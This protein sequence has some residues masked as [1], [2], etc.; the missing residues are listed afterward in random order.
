MGKGCLAK[1]IPSKLISSYIQIP[2]EGFILRYV[3]QD[4]CIIHFKR[5]LCSSH[6]MNNIKDLYNLYLFVRITICAYTQIAMTNYNLST[7]LS[8]F[9]SIF[10]F[11]YLKILECFIKTTG[12]TLA[13]RKNIIITHT[14]QTYCFFK[15]MTS[16]CTIIP[17]QSTQIRPVSCIIVSKLK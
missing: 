4:A 10:E 2:M 5:T 15:V 16:I 12:K 13:K 17:Y 7:A 14:T 11:L 9:M 1:F 8:Q 3:S 6:L